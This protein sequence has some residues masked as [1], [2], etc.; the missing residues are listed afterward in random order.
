MIEHGA[1]ARPEGWQ[2]PVQPLLA[3]LCPLLAVADT[4]LEALAL[5]LIGLATL[6]CIWPLRRSAIIPAGGERVLAG[7]LIAAA[8]ST[9]LGL[10]LHAGLPMLAARIAPG[11]PLLAALGLL[12]TG[13]PDGG[14][15]PAGLGFVPYA[16]GAGLLTGLG[17]LREWLATGQVLGDAA[18]VLGE[19]AAPLTLTPALRPALPL[20]AAPAG[21]LLLL[22]GALLVYRRLRRRADGRTPA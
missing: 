18:R 13:E 5:G 11:L 16:G 2:R 7:L 10:V 3:G 6:T 4:A 20:A 22:V 17:A 14:L 21:G 19:W 1:A 15:R 9:S 12:V 8:V